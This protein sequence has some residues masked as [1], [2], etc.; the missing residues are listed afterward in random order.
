MTKRH[1]YLP[2][3]KV[4]PGMV[5]AE[6]LLEKMGH[7]LLPAG[8]TLT[9]GSLKSLAQHDVHLLAIE[10]SAGETVEPAEDPQVR[11]DRLEYLFRHGPHPVP[12]S[13]LHDY[14]R[15][16]LSQEQA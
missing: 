15:S 3:A 8:V 4:V 11:L 16:Y 12:T 1:Y 5:L 13:I 7:V 9:E 6:D 2:L 10:R 14:V